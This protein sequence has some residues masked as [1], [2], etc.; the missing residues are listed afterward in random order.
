[1]KDFTKKGPRGLIKSI[2][3]VAPLYIDIA[4]VADLQLNTMQTWQSLYLDVG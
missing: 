3:N 1:M 4:S 2:W